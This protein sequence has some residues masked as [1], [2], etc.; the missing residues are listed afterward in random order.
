MKLATGVNA[1]KLISSS[2]TKRQNKLECLSLASF[3]RLNIYYQV[4]PG[5]C[6][7]SEHLESVPRE[8]L[9]ILD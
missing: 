1:V 2:L 5:A 8:L 7:T 4:Q 9:K 6:P 3:S